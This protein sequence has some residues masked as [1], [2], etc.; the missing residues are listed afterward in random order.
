LAAIGSA[1]AYTHTL[2]THPTHHTVH[3]HTRTPTH[4]RISHIFAHPRT[5]SGPL[6]S[7]PQGKTWKWLTGGSN[8]SCCRTRSREDSD[9]AVDAE[10]AVPD[11]SQLCSRAGR[12][13]GWSLETEAAVA[14]EMQAGGGTTVAPAAPHPFPRQT[15]LL[16]SPHPRN[17]HAPNTQLNA[18]HTSETHDTPHSH[19]AHASDAPQTH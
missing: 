16:L 8:G 7:T 14:M 11:A 2:H 18:T 9:A 15:L 4:L 6:A 12:V 3:L 13:R 19:I 10:D 5:H 17:R 1:P